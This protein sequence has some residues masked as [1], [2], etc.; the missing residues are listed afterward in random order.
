MSDVTLSRF[1]VVVVCIFIFSYIQ[2][3]SVMFL[4]HSFSNK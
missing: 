3:K 2:L 1:F 4:L